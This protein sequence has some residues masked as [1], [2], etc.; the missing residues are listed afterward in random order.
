MKIF[1]KIKALGSVSYI[2][3][4]VLLGYTTTTIAQET[5]LVAIGSQQ[6]IS[7]DLQS[8]AR[9]EVET[10]QRDEVEIVYVRE[11]ETT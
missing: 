6:T 2:T 1:N 8:G 10:W 11:P 5:R 7:L 9:V 4:I 3:G